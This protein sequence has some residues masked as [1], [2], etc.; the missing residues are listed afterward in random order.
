MML[1]SEKLSKNNNFNDSRMKYKKIKK[2]KIK[3]KNM[4]GQNFG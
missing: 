3:N 2:N 4:S 1:Q